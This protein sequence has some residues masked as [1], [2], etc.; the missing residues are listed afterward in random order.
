MDKITNGVSAADI[1]DA[2][3]RKS[4]RSG[5]QGNCVEVAPLPTGTIAVRNSRHPH[6]P[7]LIFTHDEMAAFVDGAKAGEFDVPATAEASHDATPAARKP[8]TR[9]DD[10]P[11]RYD[12]IGNELRELTGRLLDGDTVLD[13]ETS[14]RLLRILSGVT[15][16]QQ[17]HRVD[18]NGNC[19]ICHT[20]ARRWHPSSR[21]DE[22]SVY[23]ALSI[24]LGRSLMVPAEP[25]ELAG[26]S[27]LTA[28]T[29]P[30]SR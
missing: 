16:L 1:P 3:W 6:G 15:M 29:T 10:A 19:T 27:E 17:T 23:T 22:C 28:G 11:A 30:G 9:D 7:A 25:H 12:A 5:A 18:S 14:E 2:V 4:T 13:R 24:Y 26:R 20:K 8:A 21:H